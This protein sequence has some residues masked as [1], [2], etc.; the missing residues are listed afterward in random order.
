MKLTVSV[1]TRRIPPLKSLR[2]EWVTHPGYW[3]W[4]YQL[5]DPGPNK[6]ASARWPTGWTV[7]QAALNE[8]GLRAEP[9]TPGRSAASLLRR[10]GSEQGLEMIQDSQIL[11][12][13]HDLATARGMT[14]FRDRARDIARAAADPAEGET[15]LQAVERSLGEV[16]VRPDDEEQAIATAD[17]VRRVLGG[18]REAVSAWLR[19]AEATALIVR[20]VQIICPHCGAKPWLP[21]SDLAPPVR[22]RGCGQ[23]IDHPYPDGELKFRYRA[24]EPLLRV[25]GQDVLSHLFA[26]RFFLDLFRPSYDNPSYLYGG[27]PGVDIYDSDSDQCVGEADVLLI[28]A[29]GEVVPGECKRRG[30]GLTESE[31]AKL[32]KLTERLESPWSFVATLDWGADCPDL[33]EKSVRA[34]P[35]SPRFALTGEQLL[36]WPVSGMA[37]LGWTTADSDMRAA[38]H[39]NFVDRLVHPIRRGW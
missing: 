38:V 8:R 4:G 25:V 21:V 17:E 23:I 37:A 2:P 19:W 35:A 20:G 7:L 6:L 15:A 16:V 9:S 28:L 24:G 39:A 14:W 3:D 1:T 31:L 32:E 34:L 30:N 5:D 13:L 36:T 10:M 11:N 33:W 18:S 22:C 12:W 27:Y 29:S 26:L